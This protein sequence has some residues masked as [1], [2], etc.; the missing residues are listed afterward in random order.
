LL[1]VKPDPKLQTPAPAPAPAPEPKVIIKTEVPADVQ[2]RLKHLEQRVAQ[3]E[4][5][6]SKLRAENEGLRRANA[7]LKTQV[8]KAA[9]EKQQVLEDQVSL[10][11]ATLRS[12]LYKFDDPSFL[13]N[14]AAIAADLLE[15][16]EKF[17][18]T[19]AELVGSVKTNGNT[20][21]VR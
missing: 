10:S 14:Q 21:L 15:A 2:A 5:E 4:S 3:L 18:A 19:F 17:K 7:G 16:A 1:N 20:V 9:S 11:E 13:G 6:N 12:A 8:D